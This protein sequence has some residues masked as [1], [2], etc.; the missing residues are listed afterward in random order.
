MSKMSKRLHIKYPLFLLDFNEILNCWTDCRES[1]KYQVLSK[2]IQ[3]EPSC[4]MR[5]D[6]NDEANSRFSQYCERA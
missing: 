6:G 1:I 4:S 3:W 2:S 5:T